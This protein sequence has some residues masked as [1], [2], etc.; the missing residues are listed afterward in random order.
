[1]VVVL[2]CAGDTEYKR[3]VFLHSCMSKNF[4]ECCKSTIHPYLCV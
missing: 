4:T 2:G 1:M 3:M